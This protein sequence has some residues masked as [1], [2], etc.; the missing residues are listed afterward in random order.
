MRTTR[1]IILCVLLLAALGYAKEK[2]A[3][4]VSSAECLAC[5]SDA[6]LT[7]E[8]NG[9]S[10]S[11][12]VDEGKFKGSIHGSMFQCTDCHKDIKGFPHEPAPAKV[13]CASCH[14]DEVEKFKA[15]VHGVA[16][17]GG[18]NQAATCLSCH[19]SPHEIVVAGDPNS[20]V[21]HHNIPKTCGTCHGQK[22]VMESSGRS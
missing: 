13:D 19:G 15:S 1:Y 3:P 6:G 11:L 21:A 2:P 7:K 9:K 12:H 18:N 20:T 8:V 16:R 17:A 4:S 10:V 14:A 22:F 5:H